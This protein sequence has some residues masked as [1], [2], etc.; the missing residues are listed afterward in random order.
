[1][2]KDYKFMFSMEN[3]WNIE[4]LDNFFNSLPKIE[5]FKKEI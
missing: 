1:M 3:N 2:F 5:N 4:K